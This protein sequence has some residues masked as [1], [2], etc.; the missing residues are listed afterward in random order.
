MSTTGPLANGLYPI[1]RR[2]RR[3]FIIADDDAAP[4]P[5]SPTVAALPVTESV[6]PGG[7]PKPESGPDT[8]RKK[9]R[10]EATQN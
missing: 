1:I 2:A 4:A 6:A 8:K 9:S 5:A 3:P 7:K 10:D